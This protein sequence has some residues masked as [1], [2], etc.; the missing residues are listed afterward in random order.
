M[1]V[2]RPVLRTLVAF[3]YIFVFSC[4]SASFAEGN[5]DCSFSA[6]ALY[7][8]IFCVAFSALLCSLCMSNNL[9]FLSLAACFSHF[10]LSISSFLSNILC[11]FSLSRSCFDLFFLLCIICFNAEA[12]KVF[13][14]LFFSL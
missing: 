2:V 8:E 10:I 13:T 7:D 1:R 9:F 14:L 4:E 6:F 3:R 5:L 11:C 12:H